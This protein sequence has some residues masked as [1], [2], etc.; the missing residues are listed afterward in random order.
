LPVLRA[1]QVSASLDFLATAFRLAIALCIFGAG[2]VQ[3]RA[4]FFTNVI[5][6]HFDRSETSRDHI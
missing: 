2:F 4:T 3:F 6:G 1:L 5:F